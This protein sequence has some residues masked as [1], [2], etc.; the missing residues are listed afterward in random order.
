ME[1]I[2]INEEIIVKNEVEMIVEGKLY[3][4]YVVND[5]CTGIHEILEDG[6]LVYVGK[7]LTKLTGYPMQEFIKLVEEF[8][9]VELELNYI[10]EIL[11]LDF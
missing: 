4:A 3:R 9:G 8:K 6:S 5:K 10:E 11:D 2:K 7:A 1:L